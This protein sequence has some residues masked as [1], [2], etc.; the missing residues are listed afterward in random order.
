MV[1][2]REGKNSG[3]VAQIRRETVRKERKGGVS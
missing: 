2:S 1:Y 3:N